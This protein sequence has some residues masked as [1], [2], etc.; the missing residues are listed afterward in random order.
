MW[1]QSIQSFVCV[2]MCVGAACISISVVSS[3]AHKGT[4]THP[5]HILSAAHL[6][7]LQCVKVLTLAELTNVGVAPR[8]NCM[9]LHVFLL[10]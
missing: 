8:W 1:V 6:H 9:L 10:S 2:C 3:L 7:K 5:T 4:D